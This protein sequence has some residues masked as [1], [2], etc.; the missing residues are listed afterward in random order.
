MNLISLLHPSTFLFLIGF[1]FGTISP[2]LH[3]RR[4][5][6]FFKFMGDGFIGLYLFSL[7][8]LSGACGAAIASTGALIQSVTPHKYLRK[9]IWIR[10]VVALVLSIASIYFVYK[11]PLDL[12][13]LSMVVICRFGELQHNSQRIR[14]VY[15]LTSFPWIAY[16]L[17]NNFY[18]PL[19]AC[20]IA[21]VSFFVAIIRH[22]HPQKEETAV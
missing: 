9:T 6:M 22:H 21:S 18:L 3:Q 4:R 14:I 8:G 12:L 17:L 2:Q 19:I 10:I 13:P 7:G 1:V 16:H 11:T 15:F 5:M 20:I